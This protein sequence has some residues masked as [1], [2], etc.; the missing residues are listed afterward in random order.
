MSC[1]VG[2]CLFASG[3]LTYI[4]FFDHYYRNQLQLEW[5]DIIEQ[6]NL[7][8]RAEMKNV[9]FLSKPSDRLVWEK[10]GLPS[11]EL[12]IENAIIMKNFNRYPLVID[13]SD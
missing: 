10:Q 1:L 12:C 6:I 11:D 3:F 5:R 9:E 4:G 8:M 13:P 7:K 2:D